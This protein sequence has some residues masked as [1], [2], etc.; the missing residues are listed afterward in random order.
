M[1]KINAAWH[2]ANR[3]PA[4]ATLDQRVAWHLAHLEACAC[5]QDLPASIVAE[6]ARRRIKPP[7]PKRGQ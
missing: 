1:S 3:M 2:K 5:R 6:L 4:R 7:R